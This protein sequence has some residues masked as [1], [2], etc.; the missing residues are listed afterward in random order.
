MSRHFSFGHKRFNLFGAHPGLFQENLYVGLVMVIAPTHH[1]ACSGA[2]L[3]VDFDP[4]GLAF[5][6]ET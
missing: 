1:H 5:E 3:F 2:F 4:I 6:I